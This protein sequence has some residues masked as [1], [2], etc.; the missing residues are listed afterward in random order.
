MLCQAGIM[1]EFHFGLRGAP[2][3]AEIKTI[4][5]AAVATFL[6]AYGTDRC[7]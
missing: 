2:T 6:A 7:D 4:M 3:E 1:Q 5:A